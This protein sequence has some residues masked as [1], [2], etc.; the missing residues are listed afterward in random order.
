MSGYSIVDRMKMEQHVTFIRIQPSDISQV[1]R[2]VLESLSNLSWINGFDDKY[3]REAF[4]VRAQKTIDYISAKVIKAD[5]D[6]ITSNSGEYVISELAR[7]TV[8]DNLKYLDIPLAE[9]IKEK[10]S[11]NHG[12]DF[13]SKN[14]DLVILFGESKYNASQNAYGISFSQIIQFIK[15]NKDISDILEIERFCCQQSKANFTSGK[16]GFIAAFASK[17]T[18][19]EELIQNIKENKDYKELVKYAEVICVAVNV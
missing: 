13:Y 4:K 17:T 2:E 8:V 3:I 10:T 16:K 1:L 12:F 6:E 15:E 18:P 9:I 19:T 14:L 11:R 7:R 5:D